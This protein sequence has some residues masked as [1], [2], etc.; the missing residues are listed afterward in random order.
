ME[1][2]FVLVPAQNQVRLD[3]ETIDPGAL[4]ENQLLIETDW[5]FIS[6]GTELANFT[7]IEP[8]VWQAGTWCHYPWRSGYAN[9]GTVLDTGS[10]VTRAKVGDRVFTY[11]RHE[12]YAFYEQSK[13]VY[14]VPADLPLDIAVASR[15]AGVAATAILVTTLH[16]TPTVVVFGLG[17]VG[18]LAAQM[19]RAR[20]CRVI[21]VDPVQHRRDLAASVG[22][23]VTIGGS[24]EEVQ[25]QI[26][27][28][29]DGQGAPIVVEAVGHSA[30]C[31]Q[32]L[33]A[34]R[35][36]GQLV[37]LGTPRAPVEGN[38]TDFLGEVHYRSIRVLSS[39]EWQYPMYPAINADISQYEKQRMVFDWVRE[40]RIQLE[41]LISHR[42]APREIEEAYLGLLNAKDTFT[43]VALQWK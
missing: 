31:M 41:P 42:L 26:M 7:G 43:G 20:G 30:V 8:Q 3:T 11:A 25:A 15:M 17:I 9:V 10:D 21:A 14:P 24:P 39:F 2:A 33:A 4:G 35:R 6:A 40:G 23:S 12:K 5:T 1:N 32:A 27:D 34:T 18:N 19:F 16:G 37:V 28:L 29:T 22:I 36:F 38:L 13:L